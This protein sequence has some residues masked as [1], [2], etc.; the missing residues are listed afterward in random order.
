ML[1]SRLPPPPPL[2]EEAR[3]V[4]LSSLSDGSPKALIVGNDRGKGGQGGSIVDEMTTDG[5]RTMAT[6]EQGIHW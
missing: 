4:G 6:T 1:S 5:V 3:P 2:E